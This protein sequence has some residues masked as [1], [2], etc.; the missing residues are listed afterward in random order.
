MQINFKGN[1]KN[2]LR[3]K[4]LGHMSVLSAKAQYFLKTTD[5][6]LR[7]LLFSD[8]LIEMCVFYPHK[9][10]KHLNKITLTVLLQR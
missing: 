5:H 3:T 9:V 2:M 8:H 7:K 10:L 6:F 4:M 1:H